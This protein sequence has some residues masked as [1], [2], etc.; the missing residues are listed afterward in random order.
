MLT[1][2]VKEIYSAVINKTKE[3][4]KIFITTMKKTKLVY[5]KI[6]E[7]KL[8]DIID[9]NMKSPYVKYILPFVILISF[10]IGLSMTTTQAYEIK[11]NGE[12]VAIVDN[13]DVYN[14]A[15]DEAIEV[16]DKVETVQVSKVVDDNVSIQP[17]IIPL[18]E[19]TATKPEVV[20]EI[21]EHTIHIEKDAVLYID[22]VAVGYGE[23]I[24][25]VQTILDEYAKTYYN[26]FT[27]EHE[28]SKSIEIREEFINQE[29]TKGVDYIKEMLTS[30]QKV[31]VEYTV[32]SGDTYYDIASAHNMTIEELFALNPE[33]NQEILSIDTVLKLTTD[34]PFIT[35]TTTGVET[36]QE[37]IPSPIEYQDDATKYIGEETVITQGIAG[38]SL[39]EATITYS[40]GVEQSREVL[41]ST[42]EL[43]PT[44]TIIQ[45]GTL[46]KPKTASTGSYIQP[47]SGYVSSGFG[48][49]YIFGRTE[50]HNGVDFANDYGTPIVAADGGTVTFSGTM[51][52]AGN[53]V[54][55]EH[56]DGTITRYAHNSSNLVSVGDKVYQGQ[57]IAKMGSTGLSTGNHLHF[58]LIINGTE[59]N[60][61][62][63]L[64]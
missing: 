51:E 62:D 13:I 8:R 38:S 27:L 1:R 24:E 21:V 39:N 31:E 55:I 35:V 47:T 43:E 53:I 45:R 49:R 6:K 37:E 34:T 42:V 50:F 12:T 40:N 33:V 48:Y 14:E 10:A 19:S 26:E 18:E 25:E 22:N 56:D 3:T 63:Y 32:V 2:K 29:Q 46:E 30:T 28:F 57:E 52:Y 9:L 59:V 61:L 15:K 60:P 16:I 41:S 23:S 17:V 54:V 4:R 7:F 44:I 58:E 5:S 64:Q 11:V 20:D 36:Y